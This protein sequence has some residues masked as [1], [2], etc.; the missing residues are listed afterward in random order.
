[1]GRT[2]AKRDY[3]GVSASER[4]AERRRKLL[5]AGRH[6]WGVSGINEVSVR[7]VCV[8]AQLGPRYFYEQFPDRDALL[9]AVADQLR[10]DLLTELLQR[11]L[12]EPGG[13]EAKLRAALNAFLGTIAH[14]PFVHRIFSD[15]LTGTGGLGERRRQ[16]LDTVTN[17]VLEHGPALLD[18]E[19]PSPA[20]MRRR[21]T[22]IVGGVNQLVDAWVHDPRETTAE[23]ADACTD[24]CLGVVRM[25]AAPR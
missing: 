23:L 16:A 20:E 14:D 9:L 5:D 7:G 12:D 13:I 10:E 6:I 19:P 24:L 11:G 4:R 1:M 21:A 2:A 18:F 8:E 17:L 15:I 22:F 3:R 25:L